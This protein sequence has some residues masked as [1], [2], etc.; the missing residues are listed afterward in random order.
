MLANKRLVVVFQAGYSVSWH[1]YCYCY[2]SDGTA[3][4]T[5]CV[6]TGLSAPLF[7]QFLKS[8]IATVD[9]DVTLTCQ[10]TGTPAPSITW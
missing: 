6:V 9:E 10:I 7:L 3:I 8:T 4:I 2:K 5:M 1:H